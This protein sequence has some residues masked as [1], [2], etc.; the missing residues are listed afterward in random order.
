MLQNIQKVSPFT[1]TYRF[2]SVPNLKNSKIRFYT[3]PDSLWWK[4]NRQTDFESTNAYTIQQI[5][6]DLRTQ[7]WNQFE[8][9]ETENKGYRANGD[10]HPHSWSIVNARNLME[11]IKE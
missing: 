4:E 6:K 11:W 8:L 10:R 7:N 5:G 1:L 3:E 2:T 9:I